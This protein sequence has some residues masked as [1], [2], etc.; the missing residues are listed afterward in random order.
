MLRRSRVHQL[1]TGQPKDTMLLG[2]SSAGDHQ[3]YSAMIGEFQGLHPKCSVD[4]VV[5]RDGARVNH[6]EARQAP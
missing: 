1:R 2:Q 5:A 6:K 4:H 3:P